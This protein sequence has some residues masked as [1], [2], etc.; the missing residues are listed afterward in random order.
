MIGD[1]PNSVYVMRSLL[2]DLKRIKRANGF[3]TDLRQVKQPDYSPDDSNWDQAL[4]EEAPAVLLW[5]SQESDPSGRANSAEDRPTLSV[6][7]MGL[8]RQERNVQ[9][10]LQSLAVDVRRVMVQNPQRDFPGVSAT[11]SHGVWTRPA[12]NVTFDF[13]YKK[14]T[15][16]S[17]VGLFDSWWQVEYRCPRT[18]G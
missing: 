2:A 15:N 13:R 6:Y 17:T 8:V 9:E 12:G 3:L 18:T 4:A 11:N 10:A 5:L 7:L 16:A 14:M 1:V